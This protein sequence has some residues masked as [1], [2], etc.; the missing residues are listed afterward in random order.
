MLRC[1]G[2]T[3]WDGRAGQKESLRVGAPRDN[4]QAAKGNWRRVISL[5]PA[6][7]FL[8]LLRLENKT[9]NLAE[10]ASDRDCEAV[11]RGAGD[12]GSLGQVEPLALTF[13]TDIPDFSLCD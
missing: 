1:W 2:W 4:V 10:L 7:G 9:W 13:P 5:G 12:L 6:G 3:F 11:V 8:A